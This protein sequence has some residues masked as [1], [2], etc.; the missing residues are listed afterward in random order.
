MDLIKN[1]INQSISIAA[2]NLRLNNQ[3][4]EV[5]ALLKET[6]SKSDKLSDDLIN[7]KKITELSTLAIRLNDI[8]NSL[9][10]NPID[11]LK[12]SDQFKEHSRFLIKDLGHMLDVCTPVIFKSAIEKLKGI[13]KDSKEEIRVDLS[14]RVYDDEPFERSETDEIKEEIIFEEAEETETE[15]IIQNFESIILSPIKPLDNLLKKLSDNDVEY[16]ELIKFSKIMDENA[17]LSRK[18]GFEILSGMHRIVS[19]ALI[20]IKNRDLMPGKEVIESL[21][22]C[23]IV[24]VA[25]V[26]GKDV[27]INNYLNKA[28]RFG[29]QLLKIKSKDTK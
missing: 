25:V 23:L 24:I 10:Q 1:Y 16:E 15:E 21:R 20:L 11:F 7:M 13:D 14:K 22:A 4:I 8:Y 5:V 26:R 19:K 12:M 9:T 27:D 6:I 29:N 17:S 18:I 3:Q 28:E 2:N